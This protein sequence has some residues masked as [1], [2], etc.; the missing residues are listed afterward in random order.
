MSAITCESCGMPI[1]KAPHCGHC[2]DENGKLQQF[3]VRFERMVA[4]QARHQRGASREQLERNALAYMAVMPAWKN[5]PR[6]KAAFP[7][8]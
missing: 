3:D 2:V 4:W 6:I 5:H 1:T 8:G 7:D